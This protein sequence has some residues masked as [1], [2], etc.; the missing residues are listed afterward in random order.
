M[1]G[2]LG[3]EPRTRCLKGSCS[4]QLSYGPNSTAIIY[5]IWAYLAIRL[6]NIELL[7][8]LML[9]LAEQPKDERY[10]WQ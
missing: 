10:H 8:V 5:L 2:P 3:L 4:N 9:A 7:L 6:D 1:E